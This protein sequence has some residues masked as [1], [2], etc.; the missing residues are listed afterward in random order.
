MRWSHAAAVTL[1]PW[2]AFPNPSFFLQFLNCVQMLSQ[3]LLFVLF[4]FLNP[5]RFQQPAIIC[6]VL[7]LH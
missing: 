5:G 3:V 4:D 1:A 6:C 7:L 2:A